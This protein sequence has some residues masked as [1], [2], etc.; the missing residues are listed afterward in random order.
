MCG[1]VGII[2]FHSRV[3]AGLIREAASTLRLRGPDD[4]GVWTHENVGLGHRRLAVLDLT[5]AGHQPMFS[6]DGRYLIVYNGEL[7]NFQ[8]LRQL[9]DTNDAH[10]HSQSDTETILAAYARW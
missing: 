10:W 6:P 9:L 5:P 1:I 8:E 3:D 2:D 7:Y 4:S